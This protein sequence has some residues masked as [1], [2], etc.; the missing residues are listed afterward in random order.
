MLRVLASVAALA[1]ATPAAADEYYWDDDGWRVSSKSASD[2]TPYC[3]LMGGFVDDSYLGLHFV[4]TQ[5]IAAL[6]FI[7][8]MAD[9]ANFSPSVSHDMEVK[10]VVGSSV[11]DGW[12]ER[13]FTVSDG[14]EGDSRVF[15]SDMMEAEVLLNDFA[16]ASAVAFTMHDGER[17]VAV[18]D[19]DGSVTPIK[20]LRECGYSRV[21]P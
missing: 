7:I 12:G 4:P 1:L 16:K 8:L 10:F 3:M 18:F 11:D 17:V 9:A 21:V 19:L 15:T 6:S 14:S 20:K 5:N 2:G 13:N